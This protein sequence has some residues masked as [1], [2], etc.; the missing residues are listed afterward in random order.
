[1]GQ[2]YFFTWQK[3]KGAKPFEMTGGEGVFIHTPTGPVLDFASLVYQANLGHGHRRMIDAVKSQAERLCLSY[4]SADF[5]EKE[6]LAQALLQK[7]PPGF[8]KVFFCLGGSDANENALKI[9]RLVTGRYKALARYRSYHGATMGAVSL[10]GDWRRAVVEPGI[11]GVVHVL[12]LDEGRS[13]SLIPR[14]LE[15]E[16]NVGAVFLESVVGAN[17]VLIPPKD[18]FPKVR[19]ACDDHGAL[20]IV[21]EVFAGFGRTGKFFGLDH[22]FEGDCAPDM[23]TCGKAIT[24]G[25]GVLG[26]VLVHDRVAKHFEE[27]TLAAGLTHYAHPLGIAAALE[28]IRVYDDE[29]LVENAATLEAPLTQGLEKLVERF[30]CA[31]GQRCI[32]LMAALDLDLSEGDLQRLRDA[33]KAQRIHVHVK[34]RKQLRIDAGAIVITPPLNIT[35]LELKDGLERIARA[36][37]EVTQ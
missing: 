31:T 22:F 27:N 16:E 18:Y 2:S 26:A 13:E 3:Q 10:G 28:A 4:P 19:K 36:I 1:M 33:L 5:P 34:G 9:A 12:D 25:Y 37:E 24:G 21:D 8:S 14:T 29:G 30:D 17:G 35:E 7:A 32:G 20:L 11:P 6:E 23:I 15:L